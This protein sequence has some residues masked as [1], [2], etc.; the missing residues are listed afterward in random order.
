MTFTLSNDELLD[1]LQAGMY[2]LPKVPKG[3]Y[4]VYF[5]VNMSRKPGEQIRVELE[6]KT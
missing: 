2:V 5:D 4:N 3:K 6:V 1:V